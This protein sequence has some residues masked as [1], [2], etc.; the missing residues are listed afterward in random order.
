[1]FFYRKNHPALLIDYRENVCKKSKTHETIGSN[2][3]FF[4]IEN[5][6]RFFK[7]AKFEIRVSVH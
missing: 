6:F 7:I 3:S 5:K 2:N 1:M 4:L